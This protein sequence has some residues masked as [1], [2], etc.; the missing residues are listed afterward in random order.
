MNVLCRCCGSDGV[1]SLGPL[2]DAVEFAGANLQRPLPGGRLWRCKTCYFVFR[3]PILTQ[4]EYDSLYSEGASDKWV[5]EFDRIDFSLVR[6]QLPKDSRPK[7]VLDVG[8][9][10]G[11]LLTSL[12][13]QY[14]L[15]G[16]EP[17]SAAAAIARARGIEII[18]RTANELASCDQQFDVISACDVIEHVS[19][20]LDFLRQLRP[21]VRSGGRIIISTGNSDTWLWQIMKS[22]FWYCHFAEHISFIGARWVGGA[23]ATV[24]YVP[25]AL[26]KF[27]Y[28]YQW[29][30][31]RILVGMAKTA[32]YCAS[33]NVYRWLQRLGTKYASSHVPPGMGATKDHMIF[34]LELV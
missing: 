23:P 7:A 24:G 6:S 3:D 18:A 26:I 31:P 32:A 13:K 33:P 2:A 10:T 34:V 28:L 8:C 14:G 20:P 4:S 5:A 19:N 1:T 17:N 15:Y 16:V 29:P 30:D 22:R 27:N 12:P 9:F 25:V 21:L 11:Q